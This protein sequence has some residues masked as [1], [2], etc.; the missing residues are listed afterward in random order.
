MSAVPTPR[1]TAGS[2]KPLVQAHD[3]AKTFDV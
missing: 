2:S 3:L 1:A